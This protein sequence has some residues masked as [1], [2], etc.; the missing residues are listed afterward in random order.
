MKT[1]M[2]SLALKVFTAK[3]LDHNMQT[4]ASHST[5]KQNA[6]Y[7]SFGDRSLKLCKIFFDKVIFAYM[8]YHN[9]VIFK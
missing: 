2:V 5:L 3:K 7:K 8:V 6:S 4:F 9:S 1:A